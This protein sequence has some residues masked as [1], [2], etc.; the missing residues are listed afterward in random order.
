M[1]L[2]STEILIAKFDTDKVY[3]EMM[4]YQQDVAAAAPQNLL[5]RRKHEPRL[6]GC[7][8]ASR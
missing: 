2:F 3:G 6:Y 7:Y 8:Q 1:R 4:V 5:I